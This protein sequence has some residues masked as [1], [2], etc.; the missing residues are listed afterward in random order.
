MQ[1]KCAVCGIKK[2]R[3][4]KEPETKGLLS[5]LGLKTP[6]SKVPLSGDILL[7]VYEMYKIVKKILLAEDKF[8]PKMHLRQPAFTYSGFGLF[9]KNK[10]KIEKFMQTG[11]TDFIYKNDLDKACFQHD[12]A[13]DESKDFA[14]RTQ[15]EKVLRHKAFEIASNPKY[16]GYQRRLAS[17]VYKFF[18]RKSKGAGVATHAK[19]SMPNYQ[20]ANEF[21]KQIIRKCKRTKVYS[22][23]K[24]NAWGVN[25]A[26]MQSLS[27][28]NRGIKYLF[29]AIDLF[30][31]YAWVVPVKGKRGVTILKEVRYNCSAHLSVHLFIIAISSHVHIRPKQLQRIF[32]NAAAM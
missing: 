11:N 14:G 25:L 16:D 6:L 26:D 29:G 28:C 8:M 1:S 31:K 7:W 23:F 3:F 5:S 17:M 2:S 22:S 24:D 4:V 30:S 18:N 20:R 27:K 9:T 12:M 32:F 13:Y 21:H 10:R 19:K 15:S